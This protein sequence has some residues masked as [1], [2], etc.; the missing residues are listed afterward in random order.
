MGDSKSSGGLD[1]EKYIDLSCQDSVE[2]KRNDVLHASAKKRKTEA[3]EDDRE[4]GLLIFTNEEKIF[5]MKQKKTLIECNHPMSTD[6]DVNDGITEEMDEMILKMA[7]LNM[8]LEKRMQIPGQNQSR[9]TVKGA[10]KKE[11]ENET[12][13][14][15][16]R[17]RKMHIQNEKE[18]VVRTLASTLIR[19]KTSQ[20]FFETLGLG[21]SAPYPTPN[22]GSL[23]NDCICAL[24]V[25]SC[26]KCGLEIIDGDF[27]YHCKTCKSYNLCSRC[28]DQSTHFIIESHNIAE[29]HQIGG[30]TERH[31]FSRV[32]TGCPCDKKGLPPP[33]QVKRDGNSFFRCIAKFKY[34]NEDMYKEVKEEVIRHASQ[35][36]KDGSPLDA[37]VKEQYDILFPGIQVE[38]IESAVKR[39]DP[40]T[41]SYAGIDISPF[42]ANALNLVIHFV[43]RR[44]ELEF[45]IHPVG[46]AA[47]KAQMIFIKRHHYFEYYSLLHPI[48]P[49]I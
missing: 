36:L 49:H 3:V 2:G 48:P 30:N 45:K 24:G 25:C 44:S 5:V 20:K 19:H 13:P 32:E 26:D 29:A 6:K 43:D 23:H 17:L 18:A 38:C 10:I 31:L 4:D 11:L 37:A 33:F 41:E 14:D 7:L 35:Y 27:A 46:S 28:L 21:T 16:Q 9:K 39:I 47:K 15:Y 40:E 12:Y 1:F 8:E 22:P 42:V 34:D